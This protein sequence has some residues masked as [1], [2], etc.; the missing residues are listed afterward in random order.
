MRPEV[1]M[2]T[3]IPK[4]IEMIAL[5]VAATAA[6]LYGVAYAARVQPSLAGTAVKTASTGLLAAVPPQWPRPRLGS[7]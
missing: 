3:V 7:G 4:T 5:A 1:M 6:A 2:P